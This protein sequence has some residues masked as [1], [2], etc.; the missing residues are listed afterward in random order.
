MTKGGC[1]ALGH[2]CHKTASEPKHADFRRIH[3]R[4]ERGRD[5]HRIVECVQS[6]PGSAE[7]GRGKE[8][9]WL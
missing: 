1:R 3:Y 8:S 4:L 6:Q 2:S 7:T 5:N 9:E